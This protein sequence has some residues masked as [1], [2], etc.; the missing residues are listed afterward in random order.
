MKQL[1]TL[2]LVFFSLLSLVSSAESTYEYKQ[3]LET[4]KNSPK[5]EAIFNEN[6][7]RVLSN[8]QA[9][10]EI[11]K[12]LSY[13]QRIVRNIFFLMQP[14][15]ITAKTMPKLYTYV[16]EM[17]KGQHITT[18]TIFITRDIAAKQ[19][20]FNA[21]AQKIL[22]SSGAIIIGQKLLLE[23]TDAELEAVVAHEIGHIKY[24]HINKIMAINYITLLATFIYLQT[25]F[26]KQN[27][28]EGTF[29]AR[30]FGASIISDCLSSL[31]INKRFEKQA[32]EF[33]Y[34]V[35][36]KGEGCIE[37]FEDLKN[38]EKNYDNY[39]DKTYTILQEN[40]K[41][42]EPSD[43]VSLTIDYYLAS[44]GNKVDHFFKWAYHNT[45]LGAHPS[46]DAR[47]KAV[48]DYL[49]SQEQAQIQQ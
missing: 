6:A 10:I 41:N 27:D 38:K 31:I 40:K 16:D 7:P 48:K 34:K 11:D 21:M 9:S 24:N 43:S 30:I 36:G 25:T 2:G 18:P 42:L 17:C 29:I 4:F 46:N 28:S 1:R 20:M 12:E 13:F 22:M 15:V 5:Y 19:G 32:D 3:E 26:G 47:I 39:F 45:P 35:M 33:A 23:T 14:V 44:F 8:L 37:L 49:A